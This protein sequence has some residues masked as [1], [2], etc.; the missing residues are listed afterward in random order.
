MKSRR[1]SPT[2]AT[3]MLALFAA[4]SVLGGCSSSHTDTLNWIVRSANG[5]TIVIQVT[6]GACDSGVHLHTTESS[7]SVDIEA[8]TVV[9]SHGCQDSA[10]ETTKSVHLSQPLGS[11]SIT[12]CDE[13]GPSC[14]PEI[15]P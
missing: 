3:G 10:I 8:T 12:G 1:A 14:T 5:S 4:A 13:R 9:S 7:R 2:T 15:S 6:H 11:R